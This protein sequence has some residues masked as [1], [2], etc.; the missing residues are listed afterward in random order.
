MEYHNKVELAKAMM[1]GLSVATVIATM[2][3]VLPPLASLVTI[4]W[5][6]IRIYETDTVQQLLRRPPLANKE[7]D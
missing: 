1:D 5:M 2:A 6:L 7:D 3:E 4:I